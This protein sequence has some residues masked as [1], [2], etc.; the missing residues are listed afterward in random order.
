MEK[1]QQLEGFFIE[2]DPEQ[3]VEV[4][5]ELERRG[6][7]TDGAGIKEALL[8]YIL[9]EDF[10]G[11]EGPSDTERVISKARK[12]IDENPAT[13]QFG[14]NTIAGLAKMMGRKAARR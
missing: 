9:G 10:D 4:R 5:E 13:V 14:I 11:D 3:M 12:F 7:T 2:F 8:D 1:N 6:Y